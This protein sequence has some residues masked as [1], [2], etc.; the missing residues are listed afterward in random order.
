MT[1]E[2]CLL[3]SQG[4]KLHRALAKNVNLLRRWVTNDNAMCNDFWN[5]VMIVMMV[6]G[7]CNVENKFREGQ[8]SL[9]D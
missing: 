9:L 5:I 6:A 8:S 2:D 3:G 7:N 1:E 4:S